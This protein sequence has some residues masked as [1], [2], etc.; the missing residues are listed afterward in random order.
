MCYLVSFSIFKNIDIKHVA[1]SEYHGEHQSAII[2]LKSSICGSLNNVRFSDR[3]YTKLT[4][5]FQKDDIFSVG[6]EGENLQKTLLCSIGDRKLSEEAVL[7]IGYKNSKQLEK[8]YYDCPRKLGAPWRY[9]PSSIYN[10]G[11][12]IK[13]TGPFGDVTIIKKDNGEVEINKNLRS[14]LQKM[15]FGWKK[16]SYSGKIDVRKDMNQD[17]DSFSKDV[18]INRGPYGNINIYKNGDTKELKFKLKEDSKKIIE[19]LPHNSR[20]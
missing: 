18:T 12:A 8:F 1:F 2:F 17:R 3:K 5:T 14:F 7:T 6:I 19:I 10:R 15:F 4:A 13:R 9:D 16:G 20:Y 11:I